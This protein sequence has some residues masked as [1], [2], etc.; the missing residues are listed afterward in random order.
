MSPMSRDQRLNP[1]PGAYLTLPYGF[2]GRDG[3]KYTIG[4]RSPSKAG[5]QNPGPGH[6]TPFKSFIDLKALL[7]KINPLVEHLGARATPGPADYNPRD[8]FIR[9]RSPEYKMHRSSSQGRL[10][11]VGRDALLSPGPGHYNYKPSLIGDAIAYSIGLKRDAFGQ[12]NNPGPGTYNPDEKF[13]RESSPAYKIS[14]TE[15]GGNVT[16]E[17]ALAPGPGTYDGKYD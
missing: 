13:V 12:P 5:E 1:G 7:G 11:Q 8:S 9:E 3:I 15:R 17:V 16:L 4:E 10:S 6:Y 2:F 14:K